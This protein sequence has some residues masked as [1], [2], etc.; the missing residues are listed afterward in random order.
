MEI[1]RTY[2][3]HQVVIAQES[4]SLGDYLWKSPDFINH[5]IKIE[6]VKSDSYFPDVGTDEDRASN[7]QL[8]SIRKFMEESKLFRDFP[9]FISNA[10]LFITASW[11]EKHLLLLS[12]MREA[13]G[14][15]A[16]QDSP[17][18][19]VSRYH[20]YLSRN[21][22][23]SDSLEFFE[24]VK[25]NI[26]IRNALLHASGDISL[27]R[28]AKE[29]ERVVRNQTYREVRS[30]RENGGILDERGKPEIIINDGG[31]IEINRYFAFNALKYF[32]ETLLQICKSM[33]SVDEAR[34]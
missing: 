15:G 8:R 4:S 17:G 3:G 2:H 22:M 32:K 26:L 10:N 30:R 25:A 18:Q 5:E 33:Q 9:I 29:I 14:Y 16:L 13:A 6:K 12:R 21:G 28:D 24:Q 1:E 34:P 11:Y 7:A 19:G 20:K 31:V 23:P 27:S